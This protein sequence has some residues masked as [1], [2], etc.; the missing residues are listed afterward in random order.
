[1]LIT[2]NEDSDHVSNF[3]E[4]FAMQQESVISVLPSGYN[5]VINISA[6]SVSSK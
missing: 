6:I 3:V 2:A 4:N 1:M 5:A